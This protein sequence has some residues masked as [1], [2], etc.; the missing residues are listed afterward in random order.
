MLLSHGC[1][2]TLQV[3]VEAVSHTQSH[4]HGDGSCSSRHLWLC[5][6]HCCCSAMEGKGNRNV[7]VLDVL[8]CVVL[9]YVNFPSRHMYISFL[10]Y[11]VNQQIISAWKFVAAWVWI[12]LRVCGC[13]IRL[14]WLIGHVTVMLLWYPVIQSYDIGELFSKVSKT[15]LTTMLVFG[16]DIS[17]YFVWSSVYTWK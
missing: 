9:G 1:C 17:T 10:E 4:G 12:P 11:L 8:P 3:G 7:F 14:T 5:R 15:P 2:I 6:Y 16:E 13:T